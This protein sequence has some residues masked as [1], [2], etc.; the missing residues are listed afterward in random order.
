MDD[1]VKNRIFNEIA[2]VLFGYA[3]YYGAKHAILD[4]HL[5]DDLSYLFSRFKLDPKTGH[6]DIL[7]LFEIKQ[8]NKAHYGVPSYMI[9]HDHIRKMMLKPK[10]E[11]CQMIKKLLNRN[12]AQQKKK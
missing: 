7:E 3:N 6:R 4:S 5:R 12:Q 11:K 1:V 2:E 8:F 10:E 9:E